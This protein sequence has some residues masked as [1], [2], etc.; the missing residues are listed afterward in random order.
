MG[1]LQRLQKKPPSLTKKKKRINLKFIFFSLHSNQ[2]FYYLN[3]FIYNIIYN[4]QNWLTKKNK[5]RLISVS[6][7]EKKKKN[8]CRLKFTQGKVERVLKENYIRSR[9]DRAIS[10]SPL[11]TENLK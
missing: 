7:R 4:N 10:F 6:W 11:S 5:K 9:I 3:L 2:N 1:D 8:L